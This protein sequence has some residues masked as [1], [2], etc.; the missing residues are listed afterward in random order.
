MTETAFPGGG[1]LDPNSYPGTD[2]ERIEQAA[3]AAFAAGRPLRIPARR[4][5]AVSPRSFWLIDAAI[6]LPG[7]A[8]LILDN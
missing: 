5:D 6:L 7:N 8:T 1:S 4:P 3:R 2:S